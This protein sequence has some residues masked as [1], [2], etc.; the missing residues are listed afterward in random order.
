MEFFIEGTRS[1]TNKIISPK[2]GF[3]S[4]C[5][6]VFFNKDIEDISLVPVTLNYTKTLE[7]E[8]FPGELRGEAKVAESLSRTIKGASVLLMNL[9]T[10]N[11]D[12][13]DPISLSEYTAQKMKSIPNFDPFKNKKDQQTLNKDLAHDIVFELQRNIRMMPTTMVASIVLLYRKGISEVE[14]S[15]KIEWLGMIISERGANFGNDVGL[16]G[17]NTMELGLEH[18]EGYLEQHSGIYSPK[19]AEGDYK[20]YIML[21]YYRNPINQF[22]FNE[23]IVLASMHSFG[24]E[25]EW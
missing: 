13:C 11:V 19:V 3:M 20:N 25:S 5:T 7:G 10:M 6:R 22:F 12:F 9:G 15:Q 18:L 23:S 4:V 1:R 14:L 17:Q 16:P 24:L 8:S 21:T 2:F